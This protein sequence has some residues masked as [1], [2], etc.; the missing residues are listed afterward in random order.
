MSD[1]R[2]ILEA[3]PETFAEI[4]IGNSMRGPV[5]VNYWSAKA[6]PCLKLWPLLEKLVQDYSGRYLLVN[7][8]T[9]KYL[10]FAQSEL[11]ITSVPTVKMYL[12]QQVVDTIHGAESEKSFRT[13]ID[14]YM[15]RAS[16][17]L[18]LDAVRQY[19]QKDVV[20]SFEQ[21]K[22]LYQHDPDNPRVAL[23]LMKLM[24]REGQFDSLFDFHHKLSPALKKN[25]EVISLLSHAQFLHAANQVGDREQ[26]EQSLASQPDNL[27]LRFQLG[28]LNLVEDNYTAAMDQLLEIIKQ[29]RQ[30]RNEIAVKGM[31]TILNLLGSNTDTARNYR[32]KMLNAMER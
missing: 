30:Y 6:G 21:L 31:V 16:D 23:T 24:L 28:A 29:D 32:T 1:S 12:Q 13:M 26:L 2:N 15:P 17:P 3:T 4:V 10:K 22:K 5:M 18:V 9:D 14:K 27:E 11:G 20:S 19:Q 8:D 25:E 7:F